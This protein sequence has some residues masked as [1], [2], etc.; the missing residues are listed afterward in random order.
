MDA[1]S[2]SNFEV[3]ELP[4]AQRINMAYDAWKAGLGPK[5]TLDRQYG[6][7]P[8][9]LRGRINGAVSKEE[10]SQNMQRL[11]AGEETPLQEWVE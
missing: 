5:E 3:P 2:D 10:A 7:A 4:K 1:E 9:T 11:T 6:I 8:S